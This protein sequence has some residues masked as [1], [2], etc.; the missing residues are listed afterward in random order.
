MVQLDQS[1]SRERMGRLDLR[2]HEGILGHQ[3]QRAHLVHRVKMDLL[4]LQV[5]QDR[6]VLKGTVD[7]MGLPD[8]KV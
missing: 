2:D 4:V 1:V 6:Q 7:Q 8:S 3:V 5:L